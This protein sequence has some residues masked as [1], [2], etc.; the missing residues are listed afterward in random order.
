[1]AATVNAANRRVTGCC[2]S[3]CSLTSF[4]HTLSSRYSAVQQ[5]VAEQS[6]AKL[7]VRRHFC[8]HHSSEKHTSTARIYCIKMATS[9]VCYSLVMLT[10]MITSSSDVIVSTRGSGGSN[11]SSSSSRS[12]SH[13]EDADDVRRS[14][15]TLHN[16][17]ARDNGQYHCAEY[18]FYFIYL[19]IICSAWRQIQNSSMARRLSEWVRLYVPPDK[20]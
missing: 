11:H 20:I 5:S 9:V 2:C 12:S 13:D 8:L 6:S 18:L 4:W 3:E 17:L 1:M 19:F 14:R 15:D 7:C 10:V 16:L